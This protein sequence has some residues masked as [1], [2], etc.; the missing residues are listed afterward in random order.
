M[1]RAW[2]GDSHANSQGRLAHP[3]RHHS[4]WYD[5]SGIPY[6]HLRIEEDVGDAASGDRLR[7]GDRDNRRARPPHRWVYCTPTTTDRS[8]FLNGDDL[9]PSQSWK[10]M[11]GEQRVVEIG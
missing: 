5:G 3:H 11:T 1:H 8:A 10:P 6:G 4:S 9:W 7:L 2:P